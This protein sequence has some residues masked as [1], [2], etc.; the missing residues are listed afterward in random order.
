MTNLKV[1]L[2]SSQ[3]DL[4][5]D[6]GRVTIS[7]TNTG[8]TVDRVVLGA[9]PPLEAPPGTATGAAPGGTA[10]TGQAGSAGSGAAAPVTAAPA[11]VQSAVSWTEIERPLREIS[12]GATEQ[13][14]ATFNGT[15][16]AAGVHKVRFIAYSATRA[17]EEFSDQAGTVTITKTASAALPAKRAIPWWIFVVG[18]GLVLLIAAVAFVL[19]RGDDATPQTTTTK[20]TTAPPQCKSG[21]VPRLARPTD[22]VCVTPASRAQVVFENDP[23]VQ[24]ERLVQPQSTSNAYGYYTCV[25]GYVWREAFEGDVVCVDGATRARTRQENADARSNAAP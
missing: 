5:G 20:T 19:T 18:G 3:V 8:L 15:A 16:A 6:T 4:V 21:L 1:T 7:V 11:A 17:P 22:R 23:A 10:A 24:K 12:A 9:Y 2:S 14:V 13:F 25:Q